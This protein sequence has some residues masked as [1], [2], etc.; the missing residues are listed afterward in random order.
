MSEMHASPFLSSLSSLLTPRSGSEPQEVPQADVPAGFPNPLSEFVYTRTYSRWIPELGRREQWSETVER[1]VEFIAAERKLPPQIVDQVRAAIMRMDVLPSMRA[2]WSAG[3]A[4]RRDNTTM[5]NCS[6]VP[7]DSLRAF[8]ELLYILMMGTGVGFSVERQFVNNLPAV[9][10]VSGVTKFHTVPDSTVG[11]ADSFLYGLTQWFQ[12]HKVEFDFSLVRKEGAPLKTKGGRASGPD[13]LRRLFAF[14]EK[15]IL[16]AAGRNIHP[17]E[18]HDIGCMVGEIVMAGGVRRAALISISDIDD[19]QMRHAKDWSRGEFPSLR[20]MA[21]NSAFYAAKPDADTFW[22]EWNALVAS[23]SGE[24][25]LSIDSWH[26]RAGRPAGMVRPNPCGEIGL[27]Y[28]LSK[29]GITGEGGSGQFC[30]LSAAVMRAEDTIDS[31]AEKVRLA[32]WVGAIQSSFTHFPY[33]RPGWSKLCEEDRLLGVDITGQCDNPALSGNPEAMAFFNRVAIE[34]A[35][36]A[37]AYLGINMP[38]AITCGKPSGNS[39]QLVDCA[40]GFHPRFASYYIRRVRIAHSDP[41]FRLIRDAGV[42]V[43]KDNQFADWKDEDCP[44]WVAEF[45]VKAPEGAVLRNME[46]ALQQCNRYLQVIKTWC[47]DRG[48]NQS[49]TIYVRD[50]EWQEVG[51]WVFDNFDDITGLSFLPYDGGSYTLAPYEEITEET[52]NEWMS[53]YPNV[54]FTLLTH[55]EQEDRGEGAQELACMGGSCEIDWDKMAMS[56]DDAADAK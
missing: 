42:P 36:L 37:T 22:N 24:R 2:L 41:L 28:M 45:P 49:A 7:L 31:F 5:Y 27:R 55:Y 29:D 8:A 48:H 51:Q 18:A 19:E 10:P 25:G 56:Q 17:V 30:N 20:Y 32:T 26:R 47:G 15:T 53:W 40:S 38:V 34:T 33:L 52:Y 46:T 23:K 14:A 43:H 4:A 1:Y 11:W 12:G 39:S 3:E 13:P 16:A 9:A 21:N 6:F 44:T 50:A 35:A 54:D